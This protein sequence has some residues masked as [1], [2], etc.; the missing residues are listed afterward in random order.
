MIYAMTREIS[1][2][3]SNDACFLVCTGKFSLVHTKK[4]GD[5]LSPSCLSVLVAKL[6]GLTKYPM[7]EITSGRCKT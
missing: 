5:C 7:R 6:S 1:G 2:A 3:V 4:K